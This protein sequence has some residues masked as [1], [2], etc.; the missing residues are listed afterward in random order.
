MSRPC[1]IATRLLL[2]VVALAGALAAGAPAV[3][4]EAHEPRVRLVVSPEDRAAV[5]TE[6]TLTATVDSALMGSV[7][8]LDDGVAVATAELVLD[9]DVIYASAPYTPTTQGVHELTAR[10][11]GAPPDIGPA[12]SLPT[13]YSV[14]PATC[15]GQATP[16]AGA[17]VRLAYLVVLDRCPDPA[18]FAYW[19]ARLDD[20]APPSALARALAL[21]AEG[22]TATVEAAYRRVLDRSAD[23]AGRSVWAAKLR[24][25]W[26]TSQLWAALA[27][28]PEFA[29]GTADPAG[30][31]AR[32]FDR[33]VGRSVDPAGSAYWQHRLATGGPP[34]AT[35]RALVVSAEPVDGIVADA[36]QSALG[37]AASPSEADA[38]RATIRT[39]R[40]DWRLLRADLL[41]RAEAS[42]HAQRYPDPPDDA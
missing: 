29:T 18:G 4:G 36:H 31:V 26:T 9:D 5:G 12:T 33:L 30:L 37:R 7:A 13:A 21:S 19:A 38:A 34:S 39:R 16:G 25:G 24:S 2:A 42:V 41:G 40:G 27:A 15:P 3:A 22:I 17:V 6:L 32:A 14:L 35:W 20:G 8:F 10:Y 23:P 11:E 1:V 28:A